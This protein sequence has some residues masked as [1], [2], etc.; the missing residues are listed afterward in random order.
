MARPFEHSTEC[1]G[2]EMLKKG[3]WR[4]KQAAPVASEPQPARFYGI[5]PT[6]VKHLV[7]R[8]TRLPVVLGPICPGGSPSGMPCSRPRAESAAPG[9]AFGPIL[10]SL[11]AA[12]TVCYN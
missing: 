5:T 6:S 1:P 11:T 7:G 12:T 10:F 9:G 2:D 8:P 4:A 3:S